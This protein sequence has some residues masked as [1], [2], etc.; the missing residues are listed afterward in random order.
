MAEEEGFQPPCPFG[1]IGFQDRAN[2]AS[3]GTL[4][5]KNIKAFL[6]PLNT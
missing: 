4:P 1:T 2:K 5:Y 3:S 6:R